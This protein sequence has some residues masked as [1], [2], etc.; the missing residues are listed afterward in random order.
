M[1]VTIDNTMLNNIAHQNPFTW[2][3]FTSEEAIIMMPAFMTSKKNPR[4]KTVIGMVKTT[5]IGF[6]M[7]FSKD[8][9]AATSKPVI[10]E[11]I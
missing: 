9:T 1:E 7:V 3:P 5:R 4:V 10:A 8:K 6:T 11:S 2:K